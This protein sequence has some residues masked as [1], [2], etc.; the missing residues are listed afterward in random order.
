M[1]VSTVCG[2]QYSG[3]GQAN[4]AVHRAAVPPRG[5]SP[6]YVHLPWVAPWLAGG[7][8]T[9][10]LS[11]LGPPTAALSLTRGLRRKQGA[12]R[13]TKRYSST[14]PAKTRNI[15]AAVQGARQAEWMAGR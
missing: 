11:A 15:S 14:P 13:T 6:L 12:Q 3:A 8:P 1:P 5:G 10:P 9:A 7:P 4:Q 2:A